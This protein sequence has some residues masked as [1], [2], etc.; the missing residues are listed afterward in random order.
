MARSSMAKATLPIGTAERD[1]SRSCIFLDYVLDRAALTPKRFT[2]HLRGL[3][4]RMAVGLLAR[5]HIPLS[6]VQRIVHSARARVASSDPLF[7]LLCAEVP[8]LQAA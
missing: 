7:K 4:V 3:H 6:K 5:G 2:S 1:P 8:Q